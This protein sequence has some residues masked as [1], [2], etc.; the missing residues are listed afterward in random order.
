MDTLKRLHEPALLP[1][2]D[3]FQ[4]TEMKGALDL[5]DASEE[6]TATKK[7]INADSLQ[8]SFAH[9]FVNAQL[10]LAHILFLRGSAR[11]AEYFAQ[12]AYDFSSSLYA[13]AMM[14]RGLSMK[15]EL[16][17]CLRQLNTIDLTLN[18]LDDLV[19]QLDADTLEVGNSYRLRGQYFQVKE[20]EEQASEAFS[21]ATSS[22]K[23]LDASLTQLPII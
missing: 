1:S 9:G 15:T 22:I 6:S 18:Q 14:A 11:D 21:K 20:A 13:P 16:L 19:S 3:P 17:L 7:P 10:F 2:D 4:M 8:W 5:I 12:A 23:E